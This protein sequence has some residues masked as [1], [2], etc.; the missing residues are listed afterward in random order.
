MEESGD[1]NIDIFLS[2]LDIVSKCLNEA[3]VHVNWISNSRCPC[4]VTSSVQRLSND[5]LEL[6][7]LE[8]NLEG[9]WSTSLSLIKPE[10]TRIPRVQP[11]KR[12]H[13]ARDNRMKSGLARCQLCLAR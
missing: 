6:D 12:R 13:V 4:I 1:N 10:S 5:K 2:R 9:S 8:A 3:N 11:A 7:M